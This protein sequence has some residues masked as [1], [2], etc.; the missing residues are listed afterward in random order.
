[1]VKPEHPS[2][3]VENIGVQHYSDCQI[4]LSYSKKIEVD[5]VCLFI[6]EVG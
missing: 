1:M 5:D 2:G 3:S 4:A 6:L